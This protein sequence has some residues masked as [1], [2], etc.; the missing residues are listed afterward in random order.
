MALELTV[1]NIEEYGFMN[2]VLS[3]EEINL[4]LEYVY[5]SG[6][7]KELFW[8]EEIIQ[9]IVRMDSTPLAKAKIYPK[10]VYYYYLTG[11]KMRIFLEKKKVTRLL[12]LCDNAIEALRNTNRMFYLWELLCI[13][14]KLLQKH[15]I[16]ES[17][18]RLSE[19]EKCVSW[20]NVLQEICEEY[21]IPIRMYEFC[22]LYVESENYC[23]GEV[24]RVRRKMLGLSMKKLSRGICSERTISRLERSKTE[25]QKEIVKMLFDRLN[26]STELCRTEL[27]TESEEAIKKYRKLRKLNNSQEFSKMV[28]LIEELKKLIDIEIPSNKQILMRKEIICQYNLGLLSKQ[29]YVLKMKEA[30]EC[31][32]PYKVAIDSG[33]KYFTNEEIDCLQNITLELDWSFKEVE[34]YVNVMIEFWD[35]VAFPESYIR[36]YQFTMASVA[37]YLGTKGDYEASNQIE[38]RIIKLLLKNRRLGG[39]HEALYELLWNFEKVNKNNVDKE[40]LSI[41]LNRCIKFS[42][43]VKHMGRKAIYEKK[44]EEL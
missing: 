35:R 44:L 38:K 29:E 7:G 28:I 18:E 39:I 17:E 31:T 14:E 41:E 30:L 27:I 2:R 4:L 26:L 33:K 43:I 37:S 16:E 13:K 1:P 25:P 42:E 23:I 22:Y 11:D 10:V 20:K 21:G 12:E 40:K 9:Y 19:F 5:C 8:Y 3:L 24:I 15:Y 32:L 6:L 34:E 36:M